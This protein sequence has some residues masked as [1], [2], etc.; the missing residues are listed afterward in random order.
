MLFNVLF[1]SWTAILTVLAV[2]LTILPP[3]YLLG[4]VHFWT[5]SSLRLLEALVGLHYEV[6]GLENRPAGTVIV[7]AKHQSAW[8]TLGLWCVLR[9][10]SFILKQ[11]LCW[12]PV[13]GWMIPKVGMIPVD[14]S[15]GMRALRAMM[16]RAKVI[17]R[18]QRPVVIFP[19]G[20]R[21]APGTTGD[22]HP[23]IAALYSSL[24]VPVVPIALNSGLFWPRRRPQRPGKIILEF[25]PPIE[26][27][28]PRKVFLA[29]LR[30]VISEATARLE[31][32]ARDGLQAQLRSPGIA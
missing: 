2:P 27:G 19:E 6:R 16:E 28:L 3:R 14:R 25:L 4:M 30:T 5:R 32:E 17:A 11:Q 9:H 12:I 10:P 1:Y 23:G 21:V 18:Q 29:R 20:T 8:E 31:Q 24:D 13:W 26:P 15:G 7:A 22:F